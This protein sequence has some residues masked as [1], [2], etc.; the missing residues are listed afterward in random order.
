VTEISAQELAEMRDIADS[1]FPDVCVIQTVTAGVDSTGSP[2]ETFG[3]TYTNVACR[4]DPADGDEE[5]RNMALEGESSWWLNI[6]YDQAIDETWQVIH[7]S[8]T[9]Q[10]KSVWDTQSYRTIRRALMVRVG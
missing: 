10:I 3:N 9:Y 7:D 5:I 8:R 2:T 4:V 6:P 1:F